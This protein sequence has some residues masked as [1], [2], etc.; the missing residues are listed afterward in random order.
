[1]KVKEPEKKEKPKTSRK[2][3]D[4]ELESTAGTSSKSGTKRKLIAVDPK[5][6]K[7]DQ[8]FSGDS[9]TSFMKWFLTSVFSEKLDGYSVDEGDEVS[10]IAEIKRPQ[11]DPIDNKALFPGKGF[12]NYKNLTPIRF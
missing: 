10:V 9:N 1:M 11:L 6:P 8:M 12:F 2:K 7:I 5:Q 3:N 4:K